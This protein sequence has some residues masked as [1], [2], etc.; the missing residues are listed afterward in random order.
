MRN[1]RTEPIIHPMVRLPLPAPMRRW[2]QEA[3]RARWWRVLARAWRRWGEIDGDQRAAALA[4]HLML[5]LL[6][7]TILLATI[8]SLFIER[9]E[10]SRKVVQWANE[11]TPLT[12]EQER[13]AVAAVGGLLEARRTINAVAL[14]LLLW[15]SL[16]FLDSLIQTANRIWQ[17]PP[18]NWWRL[19]LKSLGLLGITVAAIFAGILLPGIP[20]L[21]EHWLGASLAAPPW[22]LAAVFRFLPWLILFAGLSLIYRL[23]PSRRPALA[24]VWIGAL[25][26]TAMIWLGQRIFLFYILHM[27]SFNLVYGALG[28]IVVLLFWIHYASSICLFG[29]CLCAAQVQTPPDSEPAVR[30]PSGGN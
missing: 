2:L 3:G 24:D 16:N 25:A 26:A 23:A 1:R 9:E 18:S 7:L 30:L 14:A 10:A 29:V 17:A 12:G 27:A 5:S 22:A 6:P 13:D 28:G 4:W 20:R 8:A 11:Y 15:G 19:P 21:V